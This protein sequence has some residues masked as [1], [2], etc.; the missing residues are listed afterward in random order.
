MTYISK[1]YKIYVMIS[2]V[3]VNVNTVLKNKAMKKAKAQGI[4]FSSVLKFAI[5]KYAEGAFEVGLVENFNTRTRK[6]IDKA[7]QDIS[8]GKNLSP[9]FST[10]AQARTW[11]DN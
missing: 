7:L 4:P 9:V 5:R 10:V 1:L 2:Q 6:E 3:I 11:L 8:K